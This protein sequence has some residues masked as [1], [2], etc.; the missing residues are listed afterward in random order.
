MTSATSFKVIPLAEDVNIPYRAH[1]A[2][3]GLD[4]FAYLP[5]GLKVVPA[6][7]AVAISA[8]VRIEIPSDYVGFVVPRSGRSLKRP[9]IIPNSPGTLDPGYQG[10]LLVIQRNVGQGAFAIEHGE[11]IAQLLFTKAEYLNPTVVKSFEAT[12]ARGTKG[13]GSTDKP[14]TSKKGS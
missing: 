10:E 6:G 13:I 8:G 7:D 1:D 5:Q 12:T 4:L 2:D 11:K 9:F 14:S 3:A